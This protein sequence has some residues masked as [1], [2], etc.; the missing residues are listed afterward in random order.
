MRGLPRLAVLAGGSGRDATGS[1]R[2]FWQG[3]VI[4]VD[5]S[6]WIDFFNGSSS[7]EVDK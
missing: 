7:P 2:C 4:V 5:S 6:V 1:G 3:A